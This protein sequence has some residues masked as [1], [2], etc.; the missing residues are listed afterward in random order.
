MRFTTLLLALTTTACAMDPIDDGD[1]DD[2]KSDQISGADDPSGLLPNAERRLAKFLTAADVGQQ[3]LVPEESTPYP[4][5]YWPMVDNG[6]AGTW[7][8]KDG[9]RCRLVNTPMEQGGG[10]ALH[11][12][13]D[14]MPS[15]LEKFMSLT[16]PGKVTDA[17]AWE[18]R[19]HGQ[20]RAGVQDWFGHCP[21]WVASSLLNG[22]VQGAVEVRFD[23]TK[24]QKCN[25]GDP[26]CVKFEI[27][28]INAMSA[29][30]HEGAESRFIGARCD[31][32]PSK[33][34]RDKFGRIVRDGSAA[35][36]STPER[37]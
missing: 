6:V 34:E 12:C 23:G 25:A 36:A 21:G 37:W 9:S 35:K 2:G 19:N 3:I 24:I 15:P 31:T 20:E 10:A 22:P 33:I 4:D 29:E 11:E 13:D 8:N 26:G 16:N 30:A 17:I 32:D 14:P 5:T 27:G 7:L 18:K 1:L 28:D